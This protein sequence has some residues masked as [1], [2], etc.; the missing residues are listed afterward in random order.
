MNNDVNVC[1][2]YP[3]QIRQGDV[4]KVYHFG[5]TMGTGFILRTEPGDDS[6]IITILFS[7]MMVET[8]LYW[9][10]EDIAVFEPV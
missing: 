4:V 7:Q 6:V 10:D 9:R 1:L 8:R 5:G 3:H 2:K